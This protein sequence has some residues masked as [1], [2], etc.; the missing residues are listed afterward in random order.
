[1]GGRETMGTAVADRCGGWACDLSNREAEAGAS[2]V[3]DCSGL[4]SKT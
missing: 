2:H 4:Y 3:G 1:M